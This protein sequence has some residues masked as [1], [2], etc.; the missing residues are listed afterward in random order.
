MTT[1]TFL[2]PLWFYIYL[3]QYCNKS[4]TLFKL[5]SKMHGHSIYS[6]KITTC[7][8][9]SWENAAS[10]LDNQSPLGDLLP[11]NMMWNVSVRL[12]LCVLCANRTDLLHRCQWWPLTWRD[13]DERCTK[14]SLGMRRMHVPNWTCVRAANRAESHSGRITFLGLIH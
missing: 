2:F 6:G 3:Q 12:K 7:G 1:K 8:P 4:F 11:R 14:S 9:A 10:G 13:L 5:G